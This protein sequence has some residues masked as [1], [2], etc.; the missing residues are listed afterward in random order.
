MKKKHPFLYTMLR[1]IIILVLLI[2]MLITAY[3][4]S[5][6]VVDSPEGLLSKLITP[7]QR[8]VSQIGQT[9]SDYLYRIKL[10]SNIEYEYNQLK[11]QNDELV[12]RSIL[13]E[14]LE[15]ENTQ[16]RA[17]LG[18]YEERASMNPLLARVIASETGNYF[19]TFTINKGKK[20]GV[21]TQMAVITSE[22]L[23][24]YVYEVFDTTS[25]VITIIDDHAS[26]AALIE[27]SRDQ[28][29]IK[30][31]L[32]STGEPLCRMYYLSADSVPRPGDRVITSGVGVSFPKGLLIGYVRESTRA[33]EDNKHY[34][35][36]EPAADFEH[37]EQVLVLRYYAD[38]EEM[39]ENYDNTEIIIAPVPTARPQAVIEEERLVNSTPIPLP[40]APGRA[41]PAPS[42]EPVREEAVQED[43]VLETP[44]PDPTEDPEMAMTDEDIFPEDL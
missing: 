6:G 28:G 21:D 16:L 25:K 15:Q 23:V 32:G 14:E 33:I 4:Q 39:P 26:L 27:S 1:R 11:A 36:V 44:M 5:S 24:G 10:R 40:E 31:T 37:I 13:Y 30:G 7:V 38:V 22:G 29:S 43:P 42:E 3:S 20:D 18:E 19:S 34:I 8:F 2:M 17:L 41:T 12:L 35:V 9:F